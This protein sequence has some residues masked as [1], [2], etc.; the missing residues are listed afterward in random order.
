MDRSD[1]LE[2]PLWTVVRAVIRHKWKASAFFVAVMV[3]VTL[4]TVLMPRTYRSQGKLLVRLG[5]ENTLLDPTITLQPD[6]VVAVPQSRENEINSVAEILNSRMLAERVVDSIG[7]ATLLGHSRK[8]AL[9]PDTKRSQIER[10]RA[11]SHLKKKFSVQPV[12]TSNVIKLVYE[13]QSPDL[14]Q[15]V[16]EKLIDFFLDEHIRL[17]RTDGAHEFFSEQ[18]T[19]SL[20]ELT[21]R[22]AELRDLRNHTGPTSPDGQRTLLV[23]RIGRLEDELYL[24]DAA[25]TASEVK[26]GMLQEK[27]AGLPEIEVTAETSGISDEGTDRMRDQFFALQIRQQ[28]AAAKYTEVHPTMQAISRQIAEARRILEQE[29]PTR[30]QVTTG[31]GQM[32][33]QTELVLLGEE[34]QLN[35]LQAK[36][37]VLR[38]QLAAVRSEWIAL[39]END[40]RI[41]ELQRETGLNE[42]NYR[43]YAAALEQSRIDQALRSQRMSNI[44]VVQP[45]TYEI[46][47]IRPRTFI[48]LLLGLLIGVFGSVGVAVAAEYWDQSLRTPDEIERKLDLPVLASIPRFRPEYLDLNGRN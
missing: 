5:R 13:S 24:T 48:N 20:E 3:T 46:K 9:Q 18:T 10:D 19:R 33:K 25:S 36:A 1:L 6:P 35:A 31:P 43:K 37:D 16:V 30:R 4:V 44:K 39:N 41:E 2:T 29:T 15:A 22:Q 42:A 45:A 12:R 7:A 28:E 27:L 32:V 23:N 8:T 14:S 26:V 17:N 40:L 21:R 11:V 38:R 47:P 34:P